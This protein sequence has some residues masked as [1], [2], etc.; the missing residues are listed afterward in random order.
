MLEHIVPLHKDMDRRTKTLLVITFKEQRK[1]TN[2]YHV[3]PVVD[4]IFNIFSL[5]WTDT[6]DDNLK[7]TN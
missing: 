6:I 3:S 1:V 4:T 2:I 7:E 5:P